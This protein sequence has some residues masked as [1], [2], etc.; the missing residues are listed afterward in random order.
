MP[1]KAISFDLNEIAQKAKDVREETIRLRGRIPGQCRLCAARLAVE[2]RKIGYPAMIAKGT[3]TLDRPDPDA[4]YPSEEHE[5]GKVTHYWV[6][7]GDL[8]IDATADQFSEEV[9]EELP[10]IIIG[11]VEKMYRHR[12]KRRGRPSITDMW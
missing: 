2:L 10:E 1:V 3:F 9:D 12:L 4:D 6:E 11:P 7:I 8:L 5:T